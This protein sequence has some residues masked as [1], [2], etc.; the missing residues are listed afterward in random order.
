MYTC[1]ASELNKKYS[2]VVSL[3]VNVANAVSLCVACAGALFKPN[4]NLAPLARRQH[5]CRRTVFL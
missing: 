2:L 4:S 3:H 5:E 1:V